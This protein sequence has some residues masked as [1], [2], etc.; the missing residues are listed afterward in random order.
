MRAM[1]IIQQ[2]KVGSF[3]NF[4]KGPITAF[5]QTSGIFPDNHI[6]LIVKVPLQQVRR[7][8]LSLSNAF[9]QG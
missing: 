3:P 1:S 6:L 4:R 5:F 7:G 2:G 8:G 9:Y